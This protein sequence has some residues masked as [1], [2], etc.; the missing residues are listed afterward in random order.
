M[1]LVRKIKRQCFNNFKVFASDT[2]F[3]EGTQEF[4]ILT[5]INNK[6]SPLEKCLKYIF[7]ST[8]LLVVIQDPRGAHDDSLTRHFESAVSLK[9]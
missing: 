3:S 2:G 8:K 6:S 5:I 9:K 7:F 4:K 1:N